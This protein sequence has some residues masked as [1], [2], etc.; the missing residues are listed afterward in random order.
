MDGHL[1][2]EAWQ[3][4]PIISDFVQRDP[5]EGEPGSERTEARVIYTDNALFVG[6]RA[7]DSRASQISAHLTRRDESSPSDWLSVMIDSYYDRRTAF[8]FSVNPAGVKRDTYRFDDT[9]DDESWDAVWDVATSRDSEGWTAE[10]RIP[11]SQL[12]FGKAD[13]QQ[14]GFNLYRRINRLAE[15]QYWQL[16]PKNESGVVSKFGDLVGIEGIDPPRRIE[17][18]PYVSSTSAFTPEEQGNPFRTGTDQ[19]A[20]VGADFNIGI[21][22]SLT[23]SATVN[24]DFGQVEADPAVV[25]LSAFE[26]FFPEKRPFFKEGIDVFR[27]S[28]NGQEQ[29]FYTRRVGRAPQGSADPR[30]GY[31]E[32]LDHTTILGAAKLSGKTADGWTMGFSGALTAS[33]RARVVD[34]TGAQFGDIVEPRSTYMVGRLSR[35]FRGGFTQLGVFGTATNR[36]L[37][38][39]LSHL[40]SAA[41]TGGLNW[42]HRFRNDTYSLEGYVV[43]SHVRGSEE[44][45]ENTQLSSAR[46]YQRPDADYV[47]FDPTRTSLTGYG[48]ELVFRRQKGSWRGGAGFNT[49]SPGL[50]LN[51]LGF[52]RQADRHMQWLWVQ[53]RWLEPGT[54]FRQFNMNV[55]QWSAWTYGWDR[56]SIGVNL[57][58]WYQLANY[59]GGW[60]GMERSFNGLATD[61]TR[62]GPALLRPGG[63]NGWGGIESDDRKSVRGSVGGWFF[64]QDDTDSW[65]NGLFA[66][67]SVRPASN[68]DFRIGPELFRQL[69]TWQY[70]QTEDVLGATR[71][72]FGELKQTTLSMTFRGNVTFT[73]D[74]SLQLYAEPFVSTGDYRGFREVADPRADTFSNRFNDYATDQLLVNEDGE[75]SVDLD[76]D[77]TGEFDV[78]NP[79][80]TFL[81][82]RSNFVLRWEYKLGSTIFFVWQHN[83]SDFNTSNRFRIGDSF[84]DIFRAPSENTFVVKVNYWLSL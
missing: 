11:F 71:Y 62:G 50:E 2:D 60:W 69:D 32:T 64:I 15:E 43:G 31:A 19:N 24:P 82:F 58:G 83:R 23:L 12:R 63:W 67:L 1:D 56:R 3:T 72:V 78:G 44:A 37:P 5:N 51:D 66:N 54:V 36:S 48:G 59:W 52:Q 14:F 42:S 29:L 84:G 61:G 25:N 20:T 39:N 17:V 76:R 22:S 16:L 13:S 18:M 9:N 80:F 79:D 49:R 8:E 68:L 35:D 4:A 74:L 73:P 77:G 40:R 10:F 6:I 70:L 46:Y 38:A 34:S 75:I 45:I 21:T 53:R 33:E 7:F 47:T 26:T 41:Y 81:S 65:G 30:G 55:N 28:I 27:F 57:N